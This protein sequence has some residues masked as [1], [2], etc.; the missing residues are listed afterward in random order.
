LM[1]SIN[2]LYIQSTF[3]NIHSYKVMLYLNMLDS[4]M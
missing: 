2:E 3:L 1:F 4:W